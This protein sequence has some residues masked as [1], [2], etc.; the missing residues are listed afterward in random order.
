M[1]KLNKKPYLLEFCE[2]GR[3]DVTYEFKTLVEARRR[4]RELVANHWE[5]AGY[6]SQIS[7]LIEV[8]RKEPNE[9]GQ[10]RIY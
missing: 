10:R 4:Q 6:F 1:M 9:M 2:L 8:R 5:S 7:K 3:D